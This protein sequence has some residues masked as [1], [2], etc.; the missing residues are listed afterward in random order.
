MSKHNTKMFD[1]A[2]K[3]GI[4]CVLIMVMGALLAFLVELSFFR[5]EGFAGFPALQ[6][7]FLAVALLFGVCVLVLWIEGWMWLIT[8]W[9]HRPMGMNMAMSLFLVVGPVFAGYILHYWKKCRG[10]AYKLT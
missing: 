5:E 7:V 9:K 3:L 8:D 4:G 2:A 6:P 1:L 10:N